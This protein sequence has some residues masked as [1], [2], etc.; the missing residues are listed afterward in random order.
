MEGS[1]HP[2]ATL[3]QLR[4]ALIT[5]RPL[6][7]LL[8]GVLAAGVVTK[9]SA[10]DFLYS[11][12]RTLPIVLITMSGFVF[13]D[14]FDKQKDILS[15]KKR[16]LPAGSLAPRFALVFGI[17][18]A[19]VAVVSELIVGNFASV[20]YSI[21]AL[22]GVV[23]YSPIAGRYPVLKEFYTAALCCVPLYYSTAIVGAK[24][25][26]D[27]VAALFLFISGRELLLDLADL[28]GDLLYGIRTLPSYLGHTSSAWIGWAV[29]WTSSAYL[30][31][32]TATP[33]ALVASL[34]LVVSLMASNVLFRFHPRLALGTSR[35]AMAF[36][37]VTIVLSI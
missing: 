10:E 15:G 23:A 21:V 33:V 9:F 4:G 26:I 34:L 32:R 5:S 18:I 14:I 35:L 12:L 22:F 20:A 17:V 19:A 36:G 2:K 27:L 29:M 25:S 7:S 3:M 31:S 6:V 13:N 16:P 1:A 11:L 28:D 8:S 37:I 24:P 30:I